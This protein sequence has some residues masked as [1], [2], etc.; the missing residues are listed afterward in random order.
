MESVH[1]SLGEQLES[2]KK[3]IERLEASLVSKREIIQGCQDLLSG[4]LRS[5]FVTG[6]G[7]RRSND[8]ASTYELAFFQKKREQRLKCVL[9]RLVPIVGSTVA[10]SFLGR[11]DSSSSDEPKVEEL[12]IEERAAGWIASKSKNIIWVGIRTRNHSEH[13]FFDLHLSVALQN[14]HSGGLARLEPHSTGLLVGYID[15]DMLRLTDEEFMDNSLALKRILSR[16]ALLH[17]SRNQNP[18]DAHVMLGHATIPIPKFPIHEQLPPDWLQPLSTMEPPTYGGPSSG[19]PIHLPPDY[20]HEDAPLIP[21]SNTEGKFTAEARYNDVW[22]SLLF[23]ANTAAFIGLNVYSFKSYANNLVNPYTT[24]EDGTTIATN[25]FAVDLSLSILFLSSIALSCGLAFG[26]FVLI[27]RKTAF[28]VKFSFLFSVF[29]MI[30][31]ALVQ[32]MSGSLFWGGLMMISG[33]LVL[34]LYKYWAERMPFAVL[35]LQTVTSVTRKYPGTLVIAFAGLFTQIAWSAFWIFSL[36]VNYSVFE[37]KS[38]CRFQDGD[39]GKTK[40]VCDNNQ[41]YM[42]MIYLNFVMFW[43]TEVIKNVVHVTIAGVFGVYYFFEGSAAGAPASPTL[44]SA[45]R[46]MTTS[47]GSIC[48]GSLL[49]A[50]LQTLRYILNSMRSDS[51]D[52]FMAFLAMCAS[53]ILSCLEG[54]FEIFNKFAFTQVAMYG[55]PFV[56]AASDTW[57]MIKDRGVDAIINDSLV[58]NVLG[59]G[60]LLV[61]VLSGLYGYLFIKV[62]QPSFYDKNDETLVIIA[63][64][65][66]EMILGAVMMSVP[67]NVLDSGVT[68]TFVA[69]A[70]DPQ[71]LYKTKPEL[72]HAIAEAY[73]NVTRNVRGEQIYHD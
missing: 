58:G 50:L 40:L 31:L 11:V 42:V 37:H 8:L 41:L 69:L 19:G 45:K 64:V 20:T 13:A 67:N 3:R 2:A 24:L 33:L 63:I 32:I 57:E 14:S 68:T 56:K 70:E 30:G 38:N 9:E 55:K 29:V 52:G 27:Q 66:L 12:Q 4:Q 6:D 71:T 59:M 53:C 54:L 15:V 5:V 72:Y 26:Y 60:S 44:G 21:K 34:F 23:A 51:D 7:S 18:E 61:A 73:P 22:A 49:I 43:N 46:A 25:A 62:V 47:F 28:L 17:F 35:L 65:V 48:F 39:D 10:T 36:A 16:T 1:G